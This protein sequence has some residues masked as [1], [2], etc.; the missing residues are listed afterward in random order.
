MPDITSL[1][2]FVYALTDSIISRSV[3]VREPILSNTPP[4]AANVM[5]APIP[6]RISVTIRP[7]MLGVAGVVD[8]RR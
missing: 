2:V 5:D 4:M 6:I 8:W 3:P 1:S 7:D